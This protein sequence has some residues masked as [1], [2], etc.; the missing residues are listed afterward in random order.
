MPRLVFSNLELDNVYLICTNTLARGQTPQWAWSTSH[1]CSVAEVTKSDMHK[2]FCT[3]ISQGALMWPSFISKKWKWN[4]TQI[5]IKVFYI[6][7]AS[8]DG[9]FEALI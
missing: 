4:T 3:A 2:S 9:N 7:L 6:Y 5:A 1:T 8:M